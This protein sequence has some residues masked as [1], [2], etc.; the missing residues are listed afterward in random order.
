MIL[1]HDE[2]LKYTL[3]PNISR[4]SSRDVPN[5]SMEIRRNIHYETFEK[6]TD[7]QDE[8]FCSVEKN[9]MQ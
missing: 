8:R 5:S 2:Q 4:E 7:N 3:S 1:N 6:T 9:L